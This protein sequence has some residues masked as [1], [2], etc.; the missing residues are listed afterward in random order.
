MRLKIALKNHILNSNSIDRQKIECCHSVVFIF[1]EG[2][3]KF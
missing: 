1:F 3:R 2:Y